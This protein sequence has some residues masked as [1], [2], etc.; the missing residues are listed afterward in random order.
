M[1]TLKEFA[2]DA[3]SLPVSGTVP[4]SRK[5]R[6][7]EAA[8]GDVHKAFKSGRLTAKALVEMYLK[9]IEAYDKKG[10]KLNAIITINPKAVKKAAA[11]DE[12][13]RK[14]G[15]TGPLHGIPVLLKDN[16]NTKEM[17]T[18][19]GSSCL[20]GYIPPADA[21][22][23]KKLEA[24]GAIIIAKANLHEFAVWGE[25]ISSILGQTL[26]PYDLSRTPGGSSGGTGAGL[27]A[28]FG[29]LGIGTDTVNSIRSPASASALYSHNL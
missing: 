29:M 20:E 12:K 14:S 2:T 16:V 3:K 7:E 5:F 19:A 18:T 23:T 9:R 15:F 13:F 6:L 1:A 4:S 25:S 11:L 24:A 27:A 10:P 28:N 22:I 17:P 8:I 26:N 21:T